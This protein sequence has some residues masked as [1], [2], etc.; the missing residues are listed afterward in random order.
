M[1]FY[2]SHARIIK[3]SFVV[4]AAIFVGVYILLMQRNKTNHEVTRVV[5]QWI[6]R[7][8]ILPCDVGFFTTNGDSVDAYFP[9]EQFKL[10]R[11]VGKDGCT[12]CRL[13]LSRY[14]QI[15]AEL[16]DSANCD[17]G[18]VCIVNPT[19]MEDLRDLLHRENYTHL[20]IWIDEAD[21]IN[22]LNQLPEITALQTFLID[23]E[24]K[25]LAVG[26]P[27]VSSKVKQL[28]ANILSNSSIKPDRLPNTSIYVENNKIQIGKVSAGDTISFSI[29]VKNIGQHKFSL[30][31]V[32]TSCDCTTAEL[33][34]ENLDVGEE[35]ILSIRFSE[36]DAIGEFYRTVEIF[37]NT[38]EEIIIEFYGKVV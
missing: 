11:Y 3:A 16:S 2:T 22:S 20:P 37:G 4:I 27:A 8:L 10:V 38:A 24:N 34:A 5:K 1:R 32:L 30:E 29:S 21:S 23:E 6:G 14:R 33:S 26:D 18:F 35:A 31:N 25:V 28:Y 17:V 36:P 19:D 13:H 12:S 15:L 7:T 9:K